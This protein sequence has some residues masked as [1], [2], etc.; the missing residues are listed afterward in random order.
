MTKR[1]KLP[2]HADERK[3]HP[4]YRGLL[5]YFPDACAAVANVSWVGNEQHNPGQDLHWSRH[6]SN[7]H[8]DCAMRHLIDAGAIDNDGTRHTA[9]AAWRILAALQLEIEAEHEKKEKV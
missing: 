8:F 3:K 4:L 9:K 1:K 7:D 6:K 5:M 2:D